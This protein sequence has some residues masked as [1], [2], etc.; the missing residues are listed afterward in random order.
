VM[1]LLVVL[2]L[3]ICLG[4]VQADSEGKTKRDFTNTPLNALT[5]II[6]SA[7][8][9]EKAIE[10]LDVALEAQYATW[11]MDT[12]NTDETFGGHVEDLIR[13]DYNGDNNDNG[14][15]DIALDVFFTLDYTLSESQDGDVCT[16]IEEYLTDRAGLNGNWDCS[17]GL[18]NGTFSSSGDYVS[19]LVYTETQ[20]NAFQN[21]VET[22]F[23]FSIWKMQQAAYDRD[24]QAWIDDEFTNTGIITH[25]ARNILDY[26]DR[27]YKCD[28][29]ENYCEIKFILSFNLDDATLGE[30]DDQNLCDSVVSFFQTNADIG[31]DWNCRVLSRSSINFPNL[32]YAIMDYSEGGGL[33]T[34]EKIGIISGSIILFLIIVGII[35]LLVVGTQSKSRADYV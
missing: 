18:G 10:F 14:Q 30:D 23:V 4:T 25:N 32:Y 20:D 31:G 6:V 16:W 13:C 27:D 12:I 3:G 33:T 17:T 7:R 9:L 22:D 2:L 21:D 5:H 28:F 15:C 34:G 29:D 11:G 8:N 1:H 26:F 35:A 24:L 19:S